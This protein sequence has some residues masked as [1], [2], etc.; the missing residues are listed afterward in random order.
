VNVTASAQYE[1]RYAGALIFNPG[2]SPVQ[3]LVVVP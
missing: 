3:S 2:T 1:W